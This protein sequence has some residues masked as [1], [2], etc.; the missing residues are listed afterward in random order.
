[1]QFRKTIT[2]NLYA[3]QQKRHRCKEQ[4]F[5]LWERKWWDDLREE[6]WNMHITMCKVDD[7]CKFDAWSRA[8][9]ASALGQPRGMG[10]GGRWEGVWD[11]DTCAPVA[12]SCQCMAKPTTLLEQ[13]FKKK[14]KT[15]DDVCIF[16]KLPGGADAVG[17]G[18]THAENHR[19]QTQSSLKR[20]NHRPRILRF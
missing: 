9:K 18:T 13:N 3:R 8:L 7:E 14:R 20:Q 11:G 2:T 17:S 12:D 1:M 4:I 5:G 6:H 19:P 15:H 16:N 10:W